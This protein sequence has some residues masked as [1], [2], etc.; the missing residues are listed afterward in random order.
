[1]ERM[2]IHRVFLSLL[3][4]SSLSSTA[5]DLLLY[6]R[7]REHERPVPIPQASIAIQADGVALFQ[8]GC[9]STG[10]Y[11][12]A[13]DVGKVWHVQ[14]AAAGK[15][16]KSIEL[17]LRDTPKSDGGYGMNVDI[18]LFAEDGT[19]EVAFLKEPIGKCRYVATNDAI[20]WDMEYTAP[21]MQ[22]LAEIYPVQYEIDA[23][24]TKVTGQ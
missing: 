18:R 7:V 24:T 20:Q 1:M 23:D 8:L 11:E 10:R 4:C 12:V 14:Y 2:R 21:R 17:D 16:S 6:G 3:V 19:K 13:L 15:V 22:R 9:D 5:Q